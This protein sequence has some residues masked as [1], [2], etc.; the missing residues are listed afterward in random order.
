MDEP[1]PSVFD[2]HLHPQGITN[3]DLESMR[4]FGVTSALAVSFASP[5]PATPAELLSHFDNIVRVQL[6]RLEQAGIR[7]YAAVGVDP[8]CGPRRGLC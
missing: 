7:G 4:F 3:Q 6:P 8:R 5:L 1:L 2:A